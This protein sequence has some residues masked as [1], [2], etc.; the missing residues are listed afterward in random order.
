MYG[1]QESLVVLMCW[2]E[3]LINVEVDKAHDAPGLGGL[4]RRLIDKTPGATPRG[5]LPPTR[6][7]HRAQVEHL[8]LHVDCGGL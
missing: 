5:A 6:L 1:A 4:F 3:R 7:H 8:T 2:N